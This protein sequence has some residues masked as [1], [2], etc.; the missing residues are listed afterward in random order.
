M[1][2]VLSYL[3]PYAICVALFVGCATSPYAEE[4]LAAIEKERSELVV[5]L[6]ALRAQ[7]EEEGVSEDV[8]KRLAELQAQLMNLKHEEDQV[9]DADRKDQMLGWAEVLGAI[10]GLGGAAG[11]GASR[12]GKS[13]SAPIVDEIQKELIAVRAALTTLANSNSHAAV[14]AA[15]I[16]ERLGEVEDITSA[17]EKGLDSTT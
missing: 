1:R 9:K 16:E 10:L 4:K 11:Y 15:A 14:T 13:R 7:V 2:N 17:F 3:I 5:E 8:D 6:E 12:L